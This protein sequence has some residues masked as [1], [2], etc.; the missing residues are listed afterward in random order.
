MEGRWLVG[1]SAEWTAVSG[2]EEGDIR[3]SSQ[4]PP[5]PRYCSLIRHCSGSHGTRI[6]GS[7][8]NLQMASSL[9]CGVLKS[10]TWA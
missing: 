2:G 3:N 8:H 1:M 4:G 6:F 10:Q 9:S 7:E 5:T